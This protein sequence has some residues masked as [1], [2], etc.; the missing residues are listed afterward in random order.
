LPNEI[1]DPHFYGQHIQTSYFDTRHFLLRKAREKGNRY[2]T[3]RVR[4][5]PNNTFAFSMKT[6][7]QKFRSEIE[8]RAANALRSEPFF[9]SDLTAMLVLPPDLLARLIELVGDNP[10]QTVVN[11]GCCRY[12]I[13]DELDRFT[14]DVGVST[15]TGKCLHCSVLEFKSTQHHEP[16]TA[17]TQM[18][19]GLIKLS[20]FLW[21]TEV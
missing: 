4:Q 19:L 10:L 12:A 15:D 21:A 17:F 18:G 13:E 20:K 1:F 11:V 2:C 8:S 14:L 5:Y 7:E 16:P 6:E 9:V 3:L